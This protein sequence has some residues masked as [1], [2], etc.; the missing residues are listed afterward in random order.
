MDEAVIPDY[1]S[2][3]ILRKVVCVKWLNTGIYKMEM[4]QFDYIC[5]LMRHLKNNADYDR[6]A[7]EGSDIWE[8][9]FTGGIT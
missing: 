6:L 2:F 8:Q 5:S 4:E 7:A 3:K 1:V 9:K